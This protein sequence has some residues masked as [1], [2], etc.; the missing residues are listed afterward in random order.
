[1]ILVNQ[2]WVYNTEFK[3]YKLMISV[4]DKWVK[5]GTNFKKSS[6]LALQ[7][8]SVIRFTELFSHYSNKGGVLLSGT[9][10]LLMLSE[11]EIDLVSEKLGHFMCES[12]VSITIPTN[13]ESLSIL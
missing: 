12:S 3:F 6:F 13:K 1:M 8:I 7:V 11:Y 10:T 2:G 5:W 4:Y 9:S